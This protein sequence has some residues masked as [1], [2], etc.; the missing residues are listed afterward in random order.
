MISTYK[1]QPILIHIHQHRNLDLRTAL[2]SLI[3]L[4]PLTTKTT[5]WHMF[6]PRR[7]PFPK[8]ASGW[9]QQSTTTCSHTLQ[10][11]M[12]YIHLYKVDIKCRVYHIIY[13][14]NPKITNSWIS[15]SLIVL[16]RYYV[17]ILGPSWILLCIGRLVLYMK[18]DRDLN[19]FD[20][21]QAKKY[22]WLRGGNCHM[23]D[24]E[25]FNT[26]CHPNCWCMGQ[27]IP[28]DE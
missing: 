24:M 15:T 9:H 20:Q 19:F 8:D 3:V 7:N 27:S 21:V 13:L 17:G 11:S 12:Y 4:F 5:T 10:I 14:Y 6:Q 1:Y 23:D 26:W 2:L 28:W 18:S 25:V 22:C 16:I